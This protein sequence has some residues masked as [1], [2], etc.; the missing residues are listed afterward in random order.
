MAHIFR[1]I[2][3][4]EQYCIERRERSRYIGTWVTESGDV[5]IEIDHKM[6]ATTY[7]F[8]DHGFAEGFKHPCEWMHLPGGEASLT[9]QAPKRATHLQVDV[10]PTDAPKATS[11]MSA[12]PIGPYALTRVFSYKLWRQSVASKVDK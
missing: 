6:E 9:V 10:F 8:L 12:C 7:G 1:P 3:R 4:V 11:F 5:R 2:V